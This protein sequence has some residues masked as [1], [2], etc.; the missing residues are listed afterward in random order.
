MLPPSE[1]GRR[2]SRGQPV[3]G[4]SP[5]SSGWGSADIRRMSYSAR[6]RSGPWASL[7]ERPAEVK[8]ARKAFE[9][10]RHHPVWTLRPTSDTTAGMTPEQQLAALRTG[11]VD[12]HSEEELLKLL[13]SGR[14]LKVKAGFDPT[15]PDLHLGHTVLMN[16]MRQFQELGHTVVFVV[17]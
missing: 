6:N 16:K 8:A 13:A 14:P 7:V 15:R 11:V 12:L 4:R 9:K 17:G 5:W 3:Q 1:N 2:G 10:R